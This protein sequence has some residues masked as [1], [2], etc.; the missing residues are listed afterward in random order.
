MKFIKIIIVLAFSAINC[1]SQTRNKSVFVELGGQSNFLSINFE[2]R[3]KKRQLNGLGFR[4]GYGLSFNKS[5]DGDV[6]FIL[7]NNIPISI[8]YLIGKKT[9]FIELGLGFA[10]TFSLFNSNERFPILSRE[11][12]K[13]TKNM[14]LFLLDTDIK[15]K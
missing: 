5:K 8:N 7:L 10:T 13:L 1:Y 9:N 2:S 14:V 11:N 15:K 4:L 12:S 3:F 6:I